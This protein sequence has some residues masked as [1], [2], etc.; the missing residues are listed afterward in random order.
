MKRLVSGTVILKEV[1]L[2][3]SSVAS[4]G[5]CVDNQSY[6]PIPNNKGWGGG[7]GGIGGLKQSEV[8]I[9]WGV[10]GDGV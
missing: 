5:E 6:S 3:L 1:D 2:Y 4:K 7:G 9:K 8:R 10:A